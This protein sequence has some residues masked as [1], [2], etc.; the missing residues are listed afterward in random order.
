M[1]IVGVGL[2]FALLRPVYADVAAKDTEVRGLEGQTVDVNAQTFSYTVET[3]PEQL[4][5]AEAAL[6]AA[7]ASQVSKAR[8]LQVLEGR[9]QLPAARTINLGDGSQ[10]TLLR[11]TLPRW[12]TLPSV[13]RPLMENTA[14]RLAR[15]HG[16]TVETQFNTPAPT[17][18]PNTIPRDII[19]W[20]LGPMTITGPFNQVMQWAR[21]WNS[22][23]LLVAVDGLQCQL[24]GRGGK[25]TANASL[26]VYI[27]PTGNENVV[28][29]P[30]GTTQGG[31]MMGGGMMMG[32]MM[33]AGMPGGGAGAVSN[34]M[35]FGTGSSP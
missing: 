26:T 6:A 11:Q 8:T 27:F 16:V 23:P 29:I 5:K 3:G 19:A 17:T 32:G 33:G 1:L 14:Q 13:V 22:A 24:A 15:K 34:P 31:G 9:K 18:D 35:P 20:T 2:Y 28:V 21:D 4:K 12:L 7:K 10:A 25:V 30:Q